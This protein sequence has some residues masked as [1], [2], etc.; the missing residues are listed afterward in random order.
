VR[1]RGADSIDMSCVMIDSVSNPEAM[2]P[3][4]MPAI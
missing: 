1:V 2:P 4:W 3:I